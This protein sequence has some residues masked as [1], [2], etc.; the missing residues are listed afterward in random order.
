MKQFNVIDS[1]T[2]KLGMRF[3]APVFFDDG[4]HMF[5]AEGKSVKRY[6][7]VAINRWKIP[8]FLTYG[9]VLDPLA[10]TQ[11]EVSL[12]AVPQPVVQPAAVQSADDVE[13]AEPVE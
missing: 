11:H 5:L 3:S 2:I 8:S 10:V 1:A 12:S 6:H 13:E 4:K 7:L 9:H